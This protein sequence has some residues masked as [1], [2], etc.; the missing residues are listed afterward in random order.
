[1]AF[2]CWLPFLTPDGYLRLLRLIPLLGTLE[3][4]FELI[5]EQAF[6]RAAGKLRE[7]QERVHTWD[8]PARMLAP[9]E[10]YLD[11]GIHISLVLLEQANSM[12]NPVGAYAHQEKRAEAKERASLLD[13]Y[14]KMEPADLLAADERTRSR[15]YEAQLTPTHDYDPLNREYSWKQNLGYGLATTAGLVGIFFIATRLHL[16]LDWLLS[17]L[18]PIP[19]DLPWYRRL[20]GGLWDYLLVLFVAALVILAFALLIYALGWLAQ[21]ALETAL[22]LAGRSLNVLARALSQDY[23]RTYRMVLFLT[24]LATL[25]TVFLP[26]ELVC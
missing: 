26:N 18:Q 3:I 1:M 12:F 8:F 10:A 7:A 22:A 16:P 23:K 4:G 21:K 19:A 5:G 2:L 20:Q 14:R 15:F 13:T 9:F 25:L 6:A 24:L 17:Q 11:W